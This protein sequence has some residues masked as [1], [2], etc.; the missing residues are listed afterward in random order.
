MATNP[1]GPKTRNLSANVP[2][3][4]FLDIQKLARICGVSVSQYVRALAEAAVMNQTMVR[5][6]L[7]DVEA[8]ESAVLAET[9]IPKIRL[10]VVPANELT[11]PDEPTASAAEPPAKYQAGSSKPR[12]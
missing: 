2:A 10:E 3:E 1:L 5:R 12:K 4:T 11:F 8:Y 9:P 6:N 7:E